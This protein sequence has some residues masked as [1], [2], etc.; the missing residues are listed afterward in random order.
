[1][2]AACQAFV[3]HP[4]RR[5]LTIGI[6]PARAEGSPTAPLGYPNPFIEIPIQTHLWQRGSEGATTGS[7][8]SVNILSSE[9]LIFV[10]GEGG[11]LS[12]AHLARLH[13]RPC[14]LFLLPE[15]LARFDCSELGKSFQD[16]VSRDLDN[17][18]S[19]LENTL[20]NHP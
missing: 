6:L 12:E 1:M 3:E 7:R 2:E 20:R 15:T 9:V 14:R 18:E 17:L 11:T 16:K 13:D 8:N 5:G 10:Y 19:W 4:E